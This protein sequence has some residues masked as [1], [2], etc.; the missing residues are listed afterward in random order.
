MPGSFSSGF[1]AGYGAMSDMYSSRARNRLMNASAQEAE[2]KFAEEEMRRQEYARAAEE[3]GIRQPSPQSATGLQGAQQAQPNQAAVA[4][5]QQSGEVD[6]VGRMAQMGVSATGTQPQASTRDQAAVAPQL[7]KDVQRVSGNE[8]PTRQDWNGYLQRRTE[9]ALRS[10]DPTVVQREL[11][12]INAV[13]QAGVQQAAAL[14]YTAAEAGDMEGAARFMTI[15]S[16]YM[17][18]GHRNEFV[19]SGD[20]IQLRRTPENA[21]QGSDSGGESNRGRTFD[22]R[23]QDVAGYAMRL[24]DPEFAAKHLLNVRAQDERER[25]A[26]VDEGQRQQQIGIQGGQLAL[27]R[28][29]FQYDQGQAKAQQG[30]QQGAVAAQVAFEQAQAA[31]QA[32][33]TPETQSALQAAQQRL[34]QAESGL[35]MSEFG[36]LRQ[37]GIRERRQDLSEMQAQARTQLQEAQTALAR[38]KAEGGT[39]E[40]RDQA[41]RR[42]RALEQRVQQSGRGRGPEM[43]RE[44]MGKLDE[45]VEN[46]LPTM[47]FNRRGEP[48]SPDEGGQEMSMQGR[49]AL[50]AWAPLFARDNP[51]MSNTALVQEL[52]QF[53]TKPP[54]GAD[55]MDSYRSPL[56]STV[57]NIPPEVQESMKLVAQRLQAQAAGAGR[58]AAAPAPAMPGLLNTIGGAGIQRPQVPSAMAPG[59]VRPGG[60]PGPLPSGLPGDSLRSLGR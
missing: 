45:A 31:H 34:A 22:L 43:T 36:S 10:G 30:R 24:M 57:I 17:P 49:A 1:S 35:T 8:N 54:R 9:I 12:N 56:S 21:P 48:A 15:A 40:Q 51:R 18:D 20:G 25:S 60:A 4:A 46:I 59:L 28:Q 53:I 58:P 50:R 11:A 3:F 14:A 37:T 6:P 19:A 55:A 39:P 13:R 16:R 47:T 26:R 38:I 2:A 7:Y 42:V 41:E 27:A 44:Q 52:G 29:R 32:N 33:P 23:R 5:E